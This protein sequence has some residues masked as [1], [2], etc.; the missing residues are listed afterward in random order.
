MVTAG[1]VMTTVANL[2]N[3][4]ALTVF[5]YEVQIPYLN[6]A[7]RDFKSQMVLA[8]M[9]VTNQRSP[10]ILIEAGVDNIGGGSGVSLPIGLV[11]V[12]QL[13]QTWAGTTNQYSPIKKYEFLPHIYDGVELNT[14][15]YWAW[16][17]GAIRFHPAN[18][19]LNIKIDMIADVLPNVT[20]EYDAL[21]VI[22][23]D[24]YLAFRAAALISMFIGANETRAQALN[25]EAKTEW[26]K[27]EAT[28][29][30]SKQQITTRRRPFM[31]AYRQRSV[32]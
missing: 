7:I 12:Q 16:M 6:I 32:G 13:W 23:C 30:K 4:P 5:S 11:E 24:D 17:G 2:M 28:G 21:P 20:S 14:I 18:T 29:N 1:Q 31:A 9:P 19:D 15:P 27:F 26:D 22:G 3:D 8:N 25:N 10:E